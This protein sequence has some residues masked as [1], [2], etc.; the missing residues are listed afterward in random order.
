MIRAVGDAVAQILMSALQFVRDHGRAFAGTW[1]LALIATAVAW[2][3]DAGVLAW[4]QAA[5][6]GTERVAMWLSS[7][8]RFENS[9]MLLALALAVVSLAGAGVRWR[10]AA[11]AC[12][13]AG[14]VGGLAVNVARP[15]FGR[16]RPHAASAPGLYWFEAAAEY[17]SL[18]SGHATS[19]MASATAVLMVMP[20]IGV[21]AVI[22]AIAIGWSR[23]QLNQHYPTDVALG[24]LLGASIGVPIGAA[25][26]A[27]GRRPRSTS[28]ARR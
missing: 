19:N 17:H 16:A 12:L 3:A 6:A 20:T 4:L 7:I 22:A 15:T 27:T 28:N 2:S 23:L 10:H 13:L 18:P 26:A 14:I 5:G 1:M 8:G 24:L 9:S 21:P 25:T 11:V